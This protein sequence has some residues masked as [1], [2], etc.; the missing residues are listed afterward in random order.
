MSAYII[1]SRND[2][3]V[4]IQQSGGFSVVVAS[5]NQAYKFGTLKHAE[6]ALRIMRLKMD[7]HGGFIIRVVKP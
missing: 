7:L 1:E 6:L 3:L 5:E 2:R 4:V